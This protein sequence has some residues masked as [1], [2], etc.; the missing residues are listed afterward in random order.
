MCA[1]R[2]LILD[3]ES[4]YGCLQSALDT[5]W[6]SFITNRWTQVLIKTAPADL[7][8]HYSAQQGWMNICRGLIGGPKCS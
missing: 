3:T 1:R 6:Y 5:D 8:F 7:D 2:D 4:Y